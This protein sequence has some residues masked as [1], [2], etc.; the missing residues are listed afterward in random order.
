MKMDLKV[1]YKA[2]LKKSE[3]IRITQTMIYHQTD[4]T[5]KLLTQRYN[6][7]SMLGNLKVY[8]KIIHGSKKK[9]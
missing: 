2:S 8:F 7:N 9:S 4:I 6:K 1:G 5:L 3:N